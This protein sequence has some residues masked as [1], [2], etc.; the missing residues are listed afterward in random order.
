M[1]Q[2]RAP[3]AAFRTRRTDSATFKRIAPAAPYLSQLIGLPTG[4]ALRIAVTAAYARGAGI[5][6]RR[7]PPGYRTTR[8]V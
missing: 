3:T 8:D 1:T 5:S 2:E 6:V 7:L 4:Y